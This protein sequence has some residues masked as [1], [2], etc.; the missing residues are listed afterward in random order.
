[1]S[2]DAGAWNED[3]RFEPV[4]ADYAAA[5]PRNAADL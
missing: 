4:A 5:G 3:A 1:M 2:E